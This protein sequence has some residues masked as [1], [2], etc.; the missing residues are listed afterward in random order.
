MESPRLLEQFSQLAQK[1]PQNKI[2]KIITV[3]LVLY[4]AYLAALTIWKF[5]DEPASSGRISAAQPLTS[6]SSSNTSSINISQ[7][8]SLN[9]FGKEETKKAPTKPKPT[10]SVAPKTRL[11]LT[12]T[13]IVADSSSE[14]SET[15][16]A[17][18]ESSGSQDTYGIGQ[19]I[20]GTSASVSQILLDRV[21]L[22]V[23]VGY[24]TLML[25]GIEYSTSIP[26]SASELND[27]I[28]VDAVDVGPTRPSR[29]AKTRKPAAYDREPERIDNRDDTELADSLREQR[30]QLFEDPKQL[31]DIIKI[32]PHREKGELL[33]Y[34]LSPGNDPTLFNQAGLKQ[35]DLAVNINGYDLTD[36]QQALSL[37][38]E[39]KELTEADI[40]VL[41]D[42]SPVQIILAL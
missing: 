30:E 3:L 40:T 38:S 12:L 42:D 37:M 36:M 16:V 32:T 18:I 11:N 2:A 27:N 13:G 41:R 26:G 10:T 14:V 1:I 7:L 25:E 4:S 34:K 6:S 39:L 35:N 29:N 21:I 24:E 31:M 19:K 22:S 5:I 23:G 20:E 9:L 33:G 17:I 15:S 8:V 28:D